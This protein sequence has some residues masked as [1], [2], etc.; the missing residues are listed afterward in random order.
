MASADC[1]PS[2]SLTLFENVR[3]SDKKKAIIQ[4]L[5]KSYL[6]RRPDNF[7]NDFIEGKGR[8]LVLLLHGPPGVGKT[9]TAKAI[10]ES[11]KTPLY[12]IAA[13][14]LGTESAKVEGLLSTVFK[15]ASH[16]FLAQHT[17]DNTP[18]NSLVSVF[19]RQLEY[20]RG[21]IFLTTNRVQ[22]FNEAVASRI[23]YGIKYRSLGVNARR[24]IWQRFLV[25][26]TTKKGNA[27]HNSNDLI[28][29]AKHELN[30]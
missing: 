7:F 13:G 6:N 22:T 30:G 4:A 19:L 17:V 16:V 10:A 11:H 27:K 20:Y 14:E 26:A 21:V 1:V 28:D 5:T 18:N 24:E 3:I 8:G 9:L 2:Y 25:K 29:L 15:V 12:A 23:H